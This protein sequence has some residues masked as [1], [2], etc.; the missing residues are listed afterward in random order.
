MCPWVYH[1]RHLAVQKLFHAESIVWNTLGDLRLGMPVLH[2]V[3]VEDETEH[4]LDFQANPGSSDPSRSVHGKISQVCLTGLE[5]SS[6]RLIVKLG[7]R[8]RHFPYSF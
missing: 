1:V 4:L 3:M 5:K 2:E 7:R 6:H 8:C